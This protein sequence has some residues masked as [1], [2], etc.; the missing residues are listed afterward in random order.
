M[1]R[2][3]KLSLVAVIVILLAIPVL[4]IMLTPNLQIT[5]FK[6]LFNVMFGVS[7]SVPPTAQVKSRL[8]L[9]AGYYLNVYSSEVSNAR[10]MR[11]TSTGDLL[12]SRPRK[13]KVTLLL[14]DRNNDGQSDGKRD[15]LLDLE[16]PHGIDIHDGWLYIAESNAIG[17][18]K[19]D[20]ISGATNGDYEH[21]LTGLGD[22]GNHWSKT[23][24]V[25]PDDWLYVTAGSTCNVCEEEDPNRA[26]MLRISLDGQQTEIYATGLRNA[27]GFDWAPWSGELYATDNGRDLMGD[28]TPPC[29]L[30][31]IERGAFYGWP[32]VNGQN[33]PDPDLGEGRELQAATAVPP[34]FEF[35]AHNAPLGITFLQHKTNAK[36]TALAALHGSWNRSTPDGYRVVALHWDADGV[37]TTSDFLTGFEEDGDIIGRPVDVVENANGDIFVSDDYAGVIYRISRSRAVAVKTNGAAIVAETAD[38]GALNE[39]LV[40]TGKSLYKK[41]G[42]VACHGSRPGQRQ[43]APKPLLR[44]ANHSQSEL[45][46]FLTTPTPPMP[47]FDLSE[48]DKVAL[49]QYMMDEVRNNSGI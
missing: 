38:N 2:Y 13:G 30:N 17:R 6:V 36:R 49:A 9:P 28:D 33:V 20:A 37:I 42:C 7:E 44:L 1:P 8:Q 29:E 25:G 14:A 45:V 43:N 21:I 39:K 4:A 22:N 41:T 31:L 24:R 19:F 48:N 15:L 32:Y 27:V 11:L 3:L 10:F 12:V 40:S 5:N 16:R 23:L 26:A 35:R 34:A 46:D 47:R 18:I